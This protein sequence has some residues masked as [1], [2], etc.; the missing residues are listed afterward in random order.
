MATCR[1]VLVCNSTGKV[2]DALHSRCLAVRVPAPTDAD[3]VAALQ[4]VAKREKFDLPDSVATS[5]AGACE[6]N[7]RRA[8]LM[9]EA[10]KAR[11]YPFGEHQQ[12][13]L[14]DWQLYVNRIAKDIMDEQ[15]PQRLLSVREKFYELLGHCI[16]APLI[17]R[18]LCDE[19]LKRIDIS[20]CRDVVHW[21]AFYERRLHE[22]SKH[23]IHLEAFVAR[24]MS[25]YKKFL[26][27]NF[28]D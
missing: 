23:I 17:L 11:Q 25:L 22:G 13:E 14:A 7:A 5:I 19:L 10:M 26:L 8:I 6:R 28:G 2:I 27:I 21:A 12:P 18:L 20:L 3:I 1:L 16:P 9:L 4:S 15:S 24:F